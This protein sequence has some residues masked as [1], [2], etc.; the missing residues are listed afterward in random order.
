[1]KLAKNVSKQPHPLA[2]QRTQAVGVFL[3]S[4]L[5]FILVDSLGRYAVLPYVFLPRV[6]L[7]P[8]QDKK[9]PQKSSG[10]TQHARDGEGHGK[11]VTF[12][13]QYASTIAYSKAI[14]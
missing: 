14:E 7:L 13:I 5:Y 6:N 1:M 8:R 9:G 11:L 10:C 12:A 2:P 3:N 4:K